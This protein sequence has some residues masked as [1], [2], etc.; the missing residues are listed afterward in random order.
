MKPTLLVIDDDCEVL[1]TSSALLRH[2]GFAVVSTSNPV[3][4]LHLLQN[5]AEIDGVVC[6]FRMPLM[7][8][9][10]LAQAAKTLRPELPVFILSGTYPPE[11][12]EAPWDAWFLKGTP[13]A[14]LVAKLDAVTLKRGRSCS[15]LRQQRTTS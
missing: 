6:D 2:L 1:E 5:N 14:D 10:E 11:R 15:G 8:G 4:A 12:H 3:E 7:N 13:I 9:E